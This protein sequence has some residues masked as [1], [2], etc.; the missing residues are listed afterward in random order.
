MQNYYTRG[1][2]AIIAFLSI[3]LISNVHAYSI[4]ETC[5]SDGLAFS[6][7]CP[8]DV[9]VSCTDE[10]WD[11]SQYGTAQYHDAYGWHDAGTPQVSY[12]LSMC[13]TGTITRTWT[14]E[15]PYWNWESCTQTIYV[16][17]VAGGFDENDIWWPSD[18]TLTGCDP[19]THP[20]VLP[21]G[22][23]YP[24]WGYADCSMVGVSYTDELYVVNANCKKIIRTWTV[25][26][27][28]Q[29]GTDWYGNPTGQWTH[30]QKIKIMNSEVPEIWC[31][32]DIH[33]SSTNCTNAE[34]VVPSLEVSATSCGGDFTVTNNSPYAY[35][36]GGNISGVYPLGWTTV[37]YT[38][39][40]GCGLTKHCT[41]KVHVTDD[42]GPTPYCYGSLAVVLMGIDNDGDG[43]NDEGMAEL[44][45]KDLNKDSSPGCGYG[46][47][48]FS[49]SPDVNDDVK[50]FTCADVGIN[51]IDMYVTDSSGNQ[52]FCTVK[53]SVQNNAANI[54]D[55][56][57]EPEDD[58]EDDN[59]DGHDSGTDSTYVYDIGG[60][61]KNSYQWGVEG[62]K[63]DL[64]DGT[65]DT[66]FI[67]NYIDT[68]EV[69]TLD[70]TLNEEGEYDIFVTI[71]TVYQTE[72]DT[73]LSSIFLTTYTNEAGNYRFDSVG[74]DST[75]Y[76]ITA[77]LDSTFKYE[78]YQTKKINAGDLQLL[79]DHLVGDRTIRSSRDLLA[80]DVDGDG[81]VDFDDLRSLYHFVVGNVDELAEVPYIIVAN[82]KLNAEGDIFGQDELNVIRRYVLGADI[83]DANFTLIERGNIVLDD[84]SGLIAA[85]PASEVVNF[86]EEA[87]N[88]IELRSAIA[89][90]SA[91]DHVTAMPNPFTDYLKIAYHTNTLDKDV[92]LEIYDATGKLMQQRTQ[93]IHN[94]DAEMNVHFDN[95]YKGL[96]IFR[97]VDGDRIHS[98]RLI[99]I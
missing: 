72:I 22:Y 27:W 48:K 24:E 61:V 81:D 89:E 4:P 86:I 49:F 14:V 46:P 67:T 3:F 6:L 64:T 38:V 75:L 85:E 60:K 25:L 59:D 74:V 88:V 54:Q 65:G 8:D 34:V 90:Y 87:N 5:E 18:I 33:V 23:D 16:T 41:V 55:C 77:T 13:N 80:A 17:G 98:G 68:T 35:S 69:I 15:D 97:I 57:P 56:E 11:L 39:K 47:L 66:T 43:I 50:F 62:V 79:M 53:V 82:E 52:A 44:W 28:C 31:P 1:R 93:R 37:K 84:N 30:M 99:R 10:I 71:D 7:N 19:E 29:E 40:Y 83:N 91:A 2:S 45:A 96:I 21:D 76:T 95:D 78:D 63:I 70:S 94:M 32:D 20:S 92:I 12:N 51:Y 73:I 42:K 58:E 36:N 9:T 26:D